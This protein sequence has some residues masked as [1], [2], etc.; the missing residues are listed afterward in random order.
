MTQGWI[1]AGAILAVGLCNALIVP[2]VVMLAI[3]GLG[4]LTSQASA[5]M[6]SANVGAALVPLAIGYLA[7]RIGVQHAL[8]ATALCY[9]FAVFY[10]LRGSRGHLLRQTR[11]NANANRRSFHREIEMTAASAPATPERAALPETWH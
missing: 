5:V 7:D 6:V 10:A 8:A 11:Y 2:I 4:P 1:A 3:S 9:A